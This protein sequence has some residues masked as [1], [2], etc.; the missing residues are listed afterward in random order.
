MKSKYYWLIKTNTNP[1]TIRSGIHYILFFPLCI[2]GILVC[3]LPWL[4][5]NQDPSVALPMEAVICISVFFGIL[6]IV[7]SIDQVHCYELTPTALIR[8]SLLRNKIHLWSEFSQ[9]VVVKCLNN[10]HSNRQGALL[11]KRDVNYDLNWAQVRPSSSNESWLI[12]I[13]LS[14]P[15]SYDETRWSAYFDKR[16]FMC[17]LNCHGICVEDRV[18]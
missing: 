10:N 17:Y 3:C 7:L 14:T 2:F 12:G 4:V 18:K 8:H 11:C 5:P 16:V 6:V 13:N 9:I 15:E 1:D